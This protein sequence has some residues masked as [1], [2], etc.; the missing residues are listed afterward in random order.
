MEHTVDDYLE[1]DG[2]QEED[3][4]DWKAPV[5]MGTDDDA[6]QEATVAMGNIEHQRT[7]VHID[8]D[9]FYAQVEMIRNPALRNKPL[10]IQQ[11]NIV[12]TT[13]YVARER[14]V[15]KLSYIKDALQK[16][17]DLVLVSGEDLTH[18]REMSYKVTEVLQRFDSAVERLGF[19]E[20]YIDVSSLV[21]GK[22]KEHRQGEESEAR[23]AGHLYKNEPI[24][25]CIC[26]CHQR[27][28]IG[29]QI[30]ME[31]RETLYKELEITSCAGV[32]HNKLLAKLV[33]GQ[34]KPN[35]QTVIYPEHAHQ[36]MISL[37]K[38]TA[39]PGIGHSTGKR[40]ASMGISTIQDLHDASKTVLE[41][42][43]GHQQACTMQQ[44]S[45]GIDKSPVTATGAPQSISDE[46]SFKK[47]CTLSDAKDRMLGMLENLLKRLKADGRVPQTIRV[48]VRKYSSPKQW[49]R[50]SRQCSLPP[51]TLKSLSK[52][53]SSTLSKLLDTCIGLFH[54]MV[55]SNKPFHLTLINICFA[56]MQANTKTS[57]N[58]DNFFSPK[59]PGILQKTSQPETSSAS[60]ANVIFTGEQHL[61]DKTSQDESCVKDQGLSTETADFKQ[62][63]TPAAKD[64]HVG[65]L[66]HFFSSPKR[67]RAK[68]SHNNEAPTFPS[69]TNSVKMRLNSL[70]S[71]VSKINP[72]SSHISSNI[73]IPSSKSRANQNESESRYLCSPQEVGNKHTGVHSKAL[74]DNIIPPDVDPKVFMELPFDVQQEL[75]SEFL[76]DLRA[77]S[78]NTEIGR[79]DIFGSTQ[80][81][82]EPS[83]SSFLSDSEDQY[84]RTKQDRTVVGQVQNKDDTSTTQGIKP[85][86]NTASVSL[87]PSNVVCDAATASNSKFSVPDDDDV[88]IPAV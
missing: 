52:D 28:A 26:G 87:S 72:T 12:V 40:L 38:A 2:D 5:M 82:N 71:F 64:T 11:K 84:V 80:N 50:E 19:D 48:T 78:I 73:K 8:L 10:G 70:D 14:N 51:G 85:C 66:E 16:C 33:G 69:Q 22:L 42:E 20:N 27:L 37:G 63:H 86:V 24:P 34:H 15:G 32:A 65:T 81:E 88:S 3:E 55:D 9:C 44:L 43:F 67:K 83:S 23:I 61:G 47:C 31:M 53:E 46:D 35:N 25:E 29:S 59:A 4:E 58:I 6:R 1:A 17:P 62:H 30:A 56:K 54:K 74:A 75:R 41:S 13:N 77:Q 57:A 76:S 79:K 18:Y 36:L 45:H 68:I 60:N 39:I 49:K 7:I 21:E